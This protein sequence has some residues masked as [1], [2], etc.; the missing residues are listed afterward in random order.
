MEKE[1]KSSKWIFLIAFIFIIAAVFLSNAKQDRG[2]QQLDNERIS[3][4]VYQ[5]SGD[6][7]C[8]ANMQGYL[9]KAQ[10][11]YPNKKLE[12]Y[13]DCDVSNNWCPR[14]SCGIGEQTPNG[15]MT[16]PISMDYDFKCKL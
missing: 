9:A 12:I 13:N 7:F 11:K 4:M 10:K 15:G 5:S 16:G 2:L 1:V 6:C 8:P 14:M 3:G